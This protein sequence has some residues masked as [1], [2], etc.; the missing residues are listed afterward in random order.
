MVRSKSKKT[1]TLS[2]SIIISSDSVREVTAKYIGPRRKGG[3]I[4]ESE[5]AAKFMRGLLR[6]QAREHFMALYLNGAH[7][8]VSFSIVFIGTANASLVHPREVFQ[9]AILCGACAIILGHN[10]PSG[11]LSP[12]SEDIAVTE[13]LKKAADLLGIKL[14]DHVIVVKDDHLSFNEKG[15]LQ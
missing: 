8:I 6:D 11:Q 15:L 14:L 3:A 13:R 10:H 7:Q 9:G 1:K 5:T 12:S 2:D 4:R